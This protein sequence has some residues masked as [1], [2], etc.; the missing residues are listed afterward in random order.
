M[1]I[2]LFVVLAT[3]L[4]MLE[5]NAV[6]V[7]GYIISQSGDTS[8]GQIDLP[9][10]GPLVRHLDTSD[11]SFS[12][13]FIGNGGKK[14][15]TP[16]EIKGFGFQDNSKWIHFESLNM[17][18]GRR[19]GPFKKFY[20][21]FVLRAFDGAIPGYTLHLK[22][23]DLIKG[24]IEHETSWWFNTKNFGWQPGE[25]S[26]TKKKLVKELKML[27]DMEDQFLE[28][29]PDKIR[30]GESIKIIMDYNEWKKTHP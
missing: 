20:R 18:E 29:I 19:V 22:L 11:I 5:A 28:T 2:T 7:P 8:K 30:K 21:F 25:F 27:F 13:K 12:I 16:A 26:N 10:G 17:A 1:K 9:Y 6:N 4:L 14:S 3:V 15:Y 24:P 23:G